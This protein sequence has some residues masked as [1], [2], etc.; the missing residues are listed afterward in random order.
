MR[1]G[2]ILSSI[3][4]HPENQFKLRTM[5][6]EA[7]MSERSFLR[8]FKEVTSCSPMDYVLRA[9]VRKA[10]RLMEDH[11]SH[12]SVTEVA[13]ACGFNDSNYF[14]RQFRRI[15]GQSPRDHL[16]NRAFNPPSA[17]H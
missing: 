13:F 2:R 15:T 16:K 12:R 8:R 17:R 6:V 1:M 11:G 4:L 5:A 9:R 10:V 14:S 3:D 7:A